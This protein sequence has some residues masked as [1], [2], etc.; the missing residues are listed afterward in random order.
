MR[1]AFRFT[2]VAETRVVTKVVSSR[3]LMDLYCTFCLF[4]SFCCLVRSCFC[5]V[6]CLF[7]LLQFSVCLVDCRLY[8]SVCLCSAVCNVCRFAV[9]LS[10]SLSLSLSCAGVSL[11]LPMRVVCVGT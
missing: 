5:L 1:F 4:S 7:V 8:L 3:F 2:T 11:S 9:S 6:V 10:L